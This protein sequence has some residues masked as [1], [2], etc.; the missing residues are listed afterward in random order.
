MYICFLLHK[1]NCIMKVSTPYKRLPSGQRFNSSCLLCS[2]WTFF[3]D[4][5]LRKSLV[6]LASIVVMQVTKFECLLEWMNNVAEALSD[7]QQS[8]SGRLWWMCS[9]GN[10]SVKIQLCFYYDHHSCWYLGV[11]SVLFENLWVET[12]KQ[13]YKF[14]L[15]SFLFLSLSLC[16]LI[17]SF[18]LLK[19]CIYFI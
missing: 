14:C 19:S 7:F 16:H 15:N 18:M 8:G 10:L 17:L 11:C 5:F 13:F 12:V 3:L 1:R 9:A 6:I 2:P 4:V